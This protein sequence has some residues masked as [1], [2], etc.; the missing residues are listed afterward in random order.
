MI[1]FIE[2]TELLKTNLPIVVVSA[3]NYQYYIYGKRTQL[4]N[5]KRLNKKFTGIEMI[6]TGIRLTLIF[7]NNETK[8]PMD[9]P[10]KPIQLH[11]NQSSLM[12][13]EKVA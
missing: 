6:L 9:K 7:K 1:R 8:N 12:M 11:Q 13:V 5:F 10:P 4:H 2:F 3:D